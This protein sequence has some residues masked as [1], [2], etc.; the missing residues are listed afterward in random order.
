MGDYPAILEAG[1]AQA[2]GAATITLDAS[3][4]GIAS[5]YVGNHI[6]ITAGTGV[7]QTRLISAYNGSQ[8][9]TITPVWTT[10]PDSTSVYQIVPM[11]R[12]DVSK[13]AGTLQTANDNGADINAILTDTNELQTDW[14]DGGRLDL[15]IDA[16]LNDTDL[17][18][19]GTSGLAK[20]ATD[21]AAILADTGELQTDWVNGG[22]LDL[23]IDLIL[24]DTGELQTDWVNGGRLDLLVD[25][26]KAVTDNLAAA[27]G[28]MVTGTV[29]HD[30]T[31][32]TTTV[33]YS[34]DITEATADHYKGRIVVF[35]SGALQYQ[36]TDITAYALDTGE[37]KFTV[38]ALTEA[39]AD[40][41][42]FVII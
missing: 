8:V 20:I 26:I 31:A 39:P 41:V 34:D 12:V 30:N 5:T 4:S 16:I 35:T 24:A 9:C 28:T 37:G 7:G 33:F 22:R 32:A 40:N 36:A 1:T 42:T 17:I 18:D 6:M 25:A 14:V 27:A 29:S 11:A 3:A 15:I 2:G 10:N 19:D 13:V 21:V 23:L 38:T